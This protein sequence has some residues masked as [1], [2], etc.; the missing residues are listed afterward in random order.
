MANNC[1]VSMRVI[2]PRKKDLTALRDIL[3]EKNT[4]LYMSA[5]NGKLCK[6]FK[7]EDGRYEGT[8][9]AICSWDCNDFFGA[10]YGEKHTNMKKYCKEHQIAA[11][12]WAQEYGMGFQQHFAIDNTGKVVVELETMDCE[13]DDVDEPIDGFYNYGEHLSDSLML[14]N[15]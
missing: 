15:G 12:C 14:P 7:R 10:D 3:R 9:K 8:I 4:D 1:Y 2:A 11:E 13:F 6:P 5:Y